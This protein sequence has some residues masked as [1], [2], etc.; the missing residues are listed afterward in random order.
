MTQTLGTVD[1]IVVG[2]G[3]GGMAAAV[4]A[5]EHGL[6]VAVIECL[7]SVGGN[8]GYSSGYASF[9]ATSMQRAAG[10]DDSADLFAAD[11]EREYMRAHVRDPGVLF[12]AVAQRYAEDSAD[13]FHW[14]AD[15]GVEFRTIIDRPAKHSVPRLHAMAATQAATRSLRR[16]LERL[17]VSISTELRA[18]R[19]ERSADGALHVLMTRVDTGGRVMATAQRAVVIATG[20]FQANFD[21][22]HEVQ[23]AWLAETPYLGVPTALGDGHRAIAAL[24]GSLVNMAF[25]PAFG[26]VATTLT[27]DAIA[28]NLHGE[29]FH[30]ETD[31]HETPVHLAEQPQQRAYYVFDEAT[32]A[33]RQTYIDGL[34]R[35]V[36]TAPTVVQLA[37]R[38]GIPAEGLTMSLERFN[39]AVEAQAPEQL[40]APRTNLPK[41]PIA[42]P[43]FHALQVVVGISVTYGGALTLPDGQVIDAHGEPVKGL[44]AVGNANGAIAPAAQVGGINLGFAFTLGRAVGRSVARQALASSATGAGS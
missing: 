40:D 15:V 30:D 39:A 12:R 2:S 26:H 33:S 29:R 25:V 27:E 8:L 6:Q 14:L 32:R 19:L 34:D 41:R 21:M 35:G 37:Q 31:P 36:T 5:A 10:I 43:P 13:A 23:R 24:G 3:P 16:E 11:L 44:Y 20:G 38:L 42:S 1:V 17:D 4:T 9:A 7:S 28:V 22:R 18:V